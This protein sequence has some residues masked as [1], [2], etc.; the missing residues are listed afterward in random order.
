MPLDAIALLAGGAVAHAAW[1]VLGKGSR[2]PTAFLWVTLTGAVLA[3]AVPVALGA[4]AGAVRLP[5]GPGLVLAGLVGVSFRRRDK[6][7]GKRSRGGC[8]VA[9]WHIQVEYCNE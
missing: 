7:D 9:G 8:C 2:R 3:L 5:A 6:I 1:N 4:R